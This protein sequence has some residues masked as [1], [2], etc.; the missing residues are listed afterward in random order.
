MDIRM[1]KKDGFKVAGLAIDAT[2]KSNFGKL[3]DELFEKVPYQQLEALGSGQSLGVCWDMK[4][5]GSFR[6]MAGYHSRDVGKA[7]ALGLELLDVPEAEYAI[8]P[9]K[10]P[11]PKNIKDGWIYVWDTFFPQQGYRHAGTPDFEVYAP[12]DLNSPDYQ[13]V[14]WVPV[15]KA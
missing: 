9:V 13:M 6:Y 12:G 10:G 15:K 3:W 7:R 4:E 2:P 14:L 11:T 1:E 5:D 8:V